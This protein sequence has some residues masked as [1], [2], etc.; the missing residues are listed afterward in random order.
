MTPRR[1]GPA[2]RSAVAAGLL[3]V[4]VAGAGSAAFAAFTGTTGASQSVSSGT[5]SLSSI[6]G[7][8]AGNR[9]TIGASNIAAG[10]TIQR[11]VTVTNTGSIA[12]ARLQLTTV[13]TTSSALTTN[14]TT[15]LRMT[16]T[17]CT[18]PWTESATTPYTYTCSGTTSTAINN[19]AVIGT[20]RTLSGAVLTAGGTNHL[21]ITLTLPAT[22]GNTLA[23]QSSVI[24]YTFTGTQRAGRAS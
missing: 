14:T 23:N 3:A 4:V 11:A 12:L 16:V 18:V 1:R 2:R 22:A 10:D 24:A 13:A 19:V 17:R 5:V 7:N 6:N 20:N 8:V 21:R 15:G 9:L